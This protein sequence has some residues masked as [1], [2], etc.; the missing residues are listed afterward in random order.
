[1]DTFDLT[2]F[3]L[4]GIADT[5]DKLGDSGVRV[6]SATVGQH[7]IHVRWHDSQRDGSWYTLTAVEKA[8]P[9]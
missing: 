7:R 5:L 3:D 8:E 2:A 9:R 4:R 1:M 6:E